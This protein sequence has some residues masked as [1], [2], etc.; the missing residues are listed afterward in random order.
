MDLGL[1]GKK[2]LITGGARGIG[3]AIALEL[4]KQGVEVIIT[5]ISDENA[6]KTLDK[7]KS[8][9]GT[10]Y[11][12]VMNVTD[13]SS[14]KDCVDKIQADIGK[15]DILINN[16]GV[17]RD[18]LFVRMKEEDWDFV[19][20]VNLKGVFNCTKVIS[21]IMMKKKWGRI[22]SISSV[23]GIMGNI[24]QANYSASKAGVIGFTKSCAQEFA[25]MNVT[26]NAIAPGFIK[27]DMTDGLSEEVSNKLLSA[28]PLKRLGTP[29]EV[30]NLVCFLASEQASYITGQT[31]GLNGGML[32]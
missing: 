3:A 15:I 21:P 12:S 27:S 32:M 13:L 2:A 31:I 9:G 20:N 4:S 5:D 24:G 29:E 7:I 14:V 1:N 11:F 6:P 8:H 28:I 22:I 25:P 18:K 10:G 23:V 16:A 19:L 30:A 26:V 17:T